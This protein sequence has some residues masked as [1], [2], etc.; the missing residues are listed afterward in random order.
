MGQD[1]DGRHVR[2]I[3]LTSAA[4][5]AARRAHATAIAGGA[6]VGAAFERAWIAYTDAAPGMSMWESQAVVAEAI[7]VWR[8]ERAD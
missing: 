2:D 8:R 7:G 1:R 4:T 6:S 3:R 5:L